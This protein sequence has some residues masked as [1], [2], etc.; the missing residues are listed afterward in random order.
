MTYGRT[1]TREEEEQLRAWCGRGDLG[2]RP[3]LG[4]MG[5]M[6]KAVPGHEVCARN[7]TRSGFKPGFAVRL[8]TS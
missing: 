6:G 3:R 1:W 2:A 4:A 8:S 5:L 7:V